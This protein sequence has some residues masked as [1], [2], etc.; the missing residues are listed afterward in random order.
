MKVVSC[1]NRASHKPEVEGLVY[2]DHFL[3]L[4]SSS[5]AC[6]QLLKNISDLFGQQGVMQQFKFRVSDG[7]V[8]FL[9]AVS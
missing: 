5:A 8:A 7:A 9:H 6:Q 3:G 4:A 1:Q 2:L